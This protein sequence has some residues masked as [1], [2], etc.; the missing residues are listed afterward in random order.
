[1]VRPDYYQA[2]KERLNQYAAN[3][4]KQHPIKTREIHKRYTNKIKEEV[5][6]HYGNGKLACVICG[7]ND[8]RALSLDHIEA[9]GNVARK[10]NGGSG[11]DL[12]AKLRRLGYPEGFQT[13]CMNCQWVKKFEKRESRNY[14]ISKSN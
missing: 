14:V 9:I 13:L 11:Y 7:F 2:H 8:V 4:Q 5:F 6:T 3:W 10:A 1:M 12:Y